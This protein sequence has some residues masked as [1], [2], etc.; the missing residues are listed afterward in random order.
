[1][2]GIVYMYTSPENKKYIGQTIRSL[3][4]RAQ[5]G[6]GY[7]GCHAFYAAILKYGWDNFQSKILYEIET[8]D[9]ENLY[10]CE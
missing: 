5:Q 9:I 6:K 10:N 8:D 2:K 3:A 1:M 4:S 7:K